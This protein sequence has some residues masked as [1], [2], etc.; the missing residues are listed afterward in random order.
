MTRGARHDPSG[1][2]RFTAKEEASWNPGL[3]RLVAEALGTFGLVAVAAGGDVA[4]TLSGGEVT[5]LAR[6]IAPGLYVMAFIY[7]M[8]DVRACTSTRR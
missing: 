6:A 1:S 3:R 7:A 8:G 4:A 5:T 2:S